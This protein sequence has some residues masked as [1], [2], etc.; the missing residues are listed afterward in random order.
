MNLHLRP[1]AEADSELIFKWRNTPFIVERSTSRRHVSR[2]EH[3]DWFSRKLTHKDSLTFIIERDGKPMGQVRLDCQEGCC[4]ISIYL[5]EEYT[6]KGFGIEAICQ[7]CTIAKNHWP[8][9]PI[10]AH[11]RSDNAVG[12]AAF[13]KAGFI[14]SNKFML[15][16]HVSFVFDDKNEEILTAR[17]YGELANIHGTSHKTLN[18][19]SR[20]GQYLR[21][22]VLA[23]IG[24]LNGK[25]ILD[26]G[27]GLGDFAGWLAENNIQVDYTGLDLT[28]ELIERARNRYPESSF[29]QGSILDQSLF[30][31]QTFDYVFSS[32]IFATYRHGAEA[33]LEG[34]VARMW[35]LTKEGLAFNSLSDWA[36]EQ[37]PGEYYASPIE[38]LSFCKNLSP[39][40]SLRHDYHSR[41]FTIYVSRMARR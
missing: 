30:V 17:L 13:S 15:P 1:I 33:W 11:V 37:E 40:V 9:L 28:V 27:C 2:D 16:N 18:W 20:E 32:G 35:N 41:D 7:A 23:E 29:F 22:K 10:V 12:Q 8:Q 39:W 24:D 36:E 26:V 6:G 25:R 21:F 14:P 4:I 31:E 34:A 5:L 38:V 19:G 3:N